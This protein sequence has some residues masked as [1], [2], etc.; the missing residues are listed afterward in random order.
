MEPIKKNKF[1]K[2]RIKRLGDINLKIDTLNSVIE[3]LNKNVRSIEINFEDLSGLFGEEKVWREECLVD[4]L[5]QAKNGSVP[6]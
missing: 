4:E 5:S 3:A 2:I 1:L 6:F